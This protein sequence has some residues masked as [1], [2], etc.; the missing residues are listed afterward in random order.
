M[1]PGFQGD[2]G[3]QIDLAQFSAT[4]LNFIGSRPFSGAGAANSRATVR[5]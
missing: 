2:E 5:P 4:E 3:D 1:S